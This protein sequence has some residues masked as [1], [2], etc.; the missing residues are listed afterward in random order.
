MEDCFVSS[1]SKSTVSERLRA[2]VLRVE[3]L[4]FNLRKILNYALK[5]S[6]NEIIITVL[7]IK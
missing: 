6:A 4:N 5:L 2:E 1:R 7:I 3:V